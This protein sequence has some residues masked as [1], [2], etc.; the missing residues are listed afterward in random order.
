MGIRLRNTESKFALL[1]TLDDKSGLRLE[2]R[3]EG[4]A[5]LPQLLPCVSVFI[6]G[7]HK[8]DGRVELE[9][10]VSS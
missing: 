4:T 5:K 1:Q 7:R 9:D 2:N 3:A 8:K 10:S 6:T